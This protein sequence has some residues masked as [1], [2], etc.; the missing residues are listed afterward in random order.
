MTA[1]LAGIGE[2]LTGLFETAEREAITTAAAADR[3][4]LAR[5]SDA[6]RA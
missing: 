4:A 2:T 3:L 1:R 6:G 5:R